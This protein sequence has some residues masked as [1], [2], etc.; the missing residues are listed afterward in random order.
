MVHHSHPKEMPLRFLMAAMGI[1]GVIVLFE[2]L[3]GLL[4]HS[5]ALISDALH[6][7]SD[8]AIMGISYGAE[9][10]ARLPSNAKMTYGYKKIE[11]VAAFVNCIIL[12][13][14]IFFILWEA[15]G[16]LI[17]PPPVPGT[18]M[19]GIATIALVG[20]TAATI[21]LK[22]IRGYNFNLRA[23]WLH[24]FQDAL[25]SGSVIIGALFIILF[26]WY[27]VDPVLSIIICL[28]IIKE[29]FR[30]LKGSIFS[31][32]D[33]VPS[34]MDFH[35]IHREL[36]SIPGVS[37]ISDLHIWQGGSNQILLSAHVCMAPGS[38]DGGE[39]VKKA[40]EILMAKYGINHATIQVLP[41]GI[42]E[43]ISCHNCN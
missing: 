41:S 32:L 38:K 2:L 30:I 37:S 40:H 1:N 36:A 27:L 8:I 7:L 28:F 5:M 25:F 33:A 35:T 4:I 24:S 3:G 14:A 23:A 6:N 31:L 16:R 18:E 11:F 22:K 9:K 29:I 10:I 13:L 20:N 12:T 15:T 26:N 17:N 19:M 42:D 34:G 21:I 39:I 43:K